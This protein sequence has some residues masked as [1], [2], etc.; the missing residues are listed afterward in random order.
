MIEIANTYTHVE[1]IVP[2]WMIDINI[3]LHGPYFQK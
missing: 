2:R 1:Y 3:S